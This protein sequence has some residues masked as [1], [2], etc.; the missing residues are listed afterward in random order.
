[1]LLWA[2]GGTTQ[3]PAGDQFVQGTSE[4]FSSRGNHFKWARLPATTNILAGRWSASKS[5][6]TKAA[7][8][9]P[10]VRRARR[11]HLLSSR[12]GL[13]PRNLYTALHVPQ[14]SLDSDQG[15]RR[16]RGCLAAV[17]FVHI[18]PQP[19]NLNRIPPSGYLHSKFIILQHGK[20]PIEF[21]FTPFSA[22]LSSPPTAQL[23][24]K[25]FP[26]LTATPS[27]GCAPLGL[28]CTAQL[29]H[30]RKPTETCTNLPVHLLRTYICLVSFCYVTPSWENLSYSQIK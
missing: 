11:A 30:P 7:V 20:L 5:S 2:W 28:L 15:P 10:Q 27:Q 18:N 17:V 26:V 29:P 13:Q 14:A 21:I 24:S 6:H 3:F 25:T 9:F 23:N 4:F 12:A 22:A 8:P 19:G 16:G 1:M